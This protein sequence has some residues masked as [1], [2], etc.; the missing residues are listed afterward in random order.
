MV[1]VPFSRRQRLS[2]LAE[3]GLPR[4]HQTIFVL[5]RERVCLVLRPLA[6]RDKPIWEAFSFPLGQITTVYGS[7]RTWCTGEPASRLPLTDMVHFVLGRI[8]HRRCL[9]RGLQRS[10]SHNLFFNVLA[11]LAEGV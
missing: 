1:A 11:T 8:R 4:T 5:E 6:N 10:M 7:C 9:G 3:Q 2:P